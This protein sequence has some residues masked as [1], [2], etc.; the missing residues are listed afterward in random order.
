MAQTNPCIGVLQRPVRFGATLLLQSPS[1]PDMQQQHL[2][3]MA[4]AALSLTDWAQ[5]FSQ[6]AGCTSGWV[7]SPWMCQSH[8]RLSNILQELLHWLSAMAWDWGTIICAIA[9]RRTWLHPLDK[10]AGGFFTTCPYPWLC[11][12]R[13]PWLF[14][15]SSVMMRLMMVEIRN[16]KK[17]K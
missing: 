2:S 13:N 17:K 5:W 9:V 6:Q 8:C 10:V 3:S 11:I 4:G 14:S 1:T 15:I 12:Y 16:F 7:W